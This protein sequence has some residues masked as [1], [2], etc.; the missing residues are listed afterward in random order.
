MAAY[1]Y[2]CLRPIAHFSGGHAQHLPVGHGA[3][4]SARLCACR[5]SQKEVMAR[6]SARQKLTCG[7]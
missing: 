7:L 1:G 6:C 3:K 4:G 2:A 5:A